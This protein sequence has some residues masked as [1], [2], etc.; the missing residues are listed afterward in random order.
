MS[1]SAPE[2]LVEMGNS[3]PELLVEMIDPAADLG[4]KAIDLLVQGEEAPVELLIERN[5]P[6]VDF[7]VHCLNA[8]VHLDDELAKFCDSGRVFAHPALQEPNA[9]FYVR[10]NRRAPCGV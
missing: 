5:D 8:V 6:I 1:N 10:R 9:F 3:A 7:P 4:T 2:F